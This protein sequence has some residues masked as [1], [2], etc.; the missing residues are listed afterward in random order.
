MRPGSEQRDSRP[1]PHCR[2]VPGAC[3]LAL[4]AAG[5]AWA[6][7][8]PSASGP[9]PQFDTDVRPVFRAKCGRCH[10]ETTR[11]ADLDLRTAAGVLKGG[12]SGAAVV[13]GRP[14]KSLL[15]EK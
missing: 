3:A 12:E 4:F 14:D 2:A 7:D 8:P 5:F 11:K 10:G 6:T 15:F 9:V 13:P 1:H